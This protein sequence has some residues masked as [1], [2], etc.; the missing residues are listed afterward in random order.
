MPLVSADSKQEAAVSKSQ[1]ARPMGGACEECSTHQHWIE[2]ELVGEDGVG[3]SGVDYLIVTPDGEE[4]RGV[5]DAKG[6]ARLQ[7][8]LPGECRIS[9]PELDKDAWRAS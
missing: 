6:A 1:S 9:F 3:I 2:V 5:T 8:V 4:H 7:N